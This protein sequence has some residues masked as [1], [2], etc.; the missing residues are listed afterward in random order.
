MRN[1]GTQRS[2]PVT[3]QIPGGELPF[4]L[5]EHCMGACVCFSLLNKDKSVYRIFI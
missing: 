2:I 4:L 1:T 3:H 5:R